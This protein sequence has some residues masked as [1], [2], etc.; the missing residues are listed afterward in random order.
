MLENIKP[1]DVMYYFE[2]L[3]KIPHGSGNVEAISDYCVDF[4]KAHHLKVRQDELLNVVIVKEASE[5]YEDAPTVILQGHLDMVCEK[6]SDVEFDFEKDALKLRVIGDEIYA[7]GTTLGGDD[8]I[9]IAMS[10]AILA[11]DSL[12]H[13]R[14][15]AVFTT[16]EETGMD[17]AN[18]LDTSD[19]QGR[20]MINMDSEGEDSILASCAGGMRADLKFPLAYDETE[21]IKADIRIDGLVG[22]HSGTEINKCRANA[23]VLLGR[24]LYGLLETVE[25]SVISLEGGAKDNAI[26]R[27]SSAQVC[28]PAEEAEAF[29]ARL[30]EL[31]SML[32]EEYQTSDPSITITCSKETSP[33]KMQVLTMQSVARFLFVLFNAPNGVQSMSA[34]LPDLV[35]SSLN[36]G[37][38]L[39]D[40][41]YLTLRYS[42]RS[43]VTSIKE[44]L[45][46]KLC[47]MTEMMG[48]IYT[49]EGKYPGWAYKPESALRTLAQ[50]TYEKLYGKRPEVLA[51]HAGLEC[52]L[53]SEKI[54]GIDIISIGPDIFDIHTPN[55]HMNIPSVGRVYAYIVKILEDFPTI[56]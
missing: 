31:T 53:I 17:G 24:V 23:N 42:I 51:L 34:D 56:F 26:A 2:E 44:Y 14:I 36:L 54:P 3:T 40:E 16:E 27:S 7:T 12:K 28:I 19:L 15:E 47:Y 55:E 10:M 39:M 38:I 43:S 20:Y 13:P 35:E 6:D 37:V 25:F 9:A 4:A 45:G 18:F 21:G 22:G 49:E 46:Q 48:G 1:Y 5:G 8:G 50:D 33:S 29:D 11:D 41:A 32:Q 52:G 30:K